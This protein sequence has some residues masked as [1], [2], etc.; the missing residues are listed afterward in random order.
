LH[1]PPWH[2]SPVVQALLSLHAFVLFVCTQPVDG[3]QLSSVQGLLSSQEM[4]SLAQA[5]PAHMPIATWHMSVTVHASLV[6]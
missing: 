6:F 4:G 2:V 5:P 3:S 1:V